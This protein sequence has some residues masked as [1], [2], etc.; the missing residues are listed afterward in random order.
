MLV[1]GAAGSLGREVCAE[2]STGGQR[3]VG[4]DQQ[5]PDERVG[6]SNSSLGPG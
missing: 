3:V 1:T 4:F 5:P 6:R 2:L